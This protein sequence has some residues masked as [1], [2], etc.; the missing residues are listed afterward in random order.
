MRKGALPLALALASSAAWAD[1]GLLPERRR[2]QFTNDP[3][4]AV[5]PYLYN[6]PGLGWG[7]GVL[8]AATN[9]GGSYADVAGT[10][11]FGDADGQAVSVDQ[12]HLVPRRLMLDAGLAHL[13]RATLKSWFKR[14]MGSGKGDFSL[15]EFGDV[16][17]AGTRLTATADERRFEAFAGWYAGMATLRALRDSGGATILSAAGAARYRA[18][19]WV[20]GLRADMTDDFIDPRRGLRLEP[21]L[22]RSPRR[23]SGPDYY[24]TDWSATAYLPLGRRSTWAFN[25]L[26]SDAH[27]LAPGVTDP[28]ALAR[29]QGLDCAS[30]PDAARRA[31]CDDYVSTLAAENANGTA[32]MLGGF[33]R[34]RSYSEGRF[35]GAH[36]EFVGSEVRWNLTDEAK[37]FD[38][39]IMKDIRT[40]VQVAFFYEA[41]TAADT[42]GELWKEWRSSAGAGV[43]I[44]TASGLVYRVDLAGG[45][46]GWQPS[47]FFQ[48]PWEL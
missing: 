7:Y 41:G 42:R 38:I 5:V 20:G 9:V 10:L 40:A 46:E 34:L 17:F 47:V 43:R 30:V 48:Y 22:W 31:Q 24:Y 36:A 25:A 44:V 2:P 45:S 23:G 21:S 35:K 11:F 39:Y 1:A 18:S 3:G 26:R 4:Y 29:D 8:G 14:G 27:V 32:T 28:A 13:S 37:P 12:V 16:A 6:L 15:A 33:R 19:T